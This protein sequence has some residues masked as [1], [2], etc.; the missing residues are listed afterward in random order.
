MRKTRI[1]LI[2][3]GTAGHLNPLVAVG[4]ELKLEA[5]KAG[6]PLEVSYMGT[7]GD[8]AESFSANDIKV[9]KIIGSKLRR[10][11]DVENLFEGPKLIIG[12]IQ[13]LW[14]LFWIMPDVVFSKGGSGAMAPV[15]AA[16]FYRI[17][18]FIHESDAVPSAT[19][20]VTG[21]FAKTIFISF[22]EVAARFAPAEQAK[23]ELVGSPLR[24]TL[25]TDLSTKEKAKKLLGLDPKKPVMLVLGGSQGS[26]RINNLIL[27]SLPD[28]LG[29]GIQVLHQ[30]GAKLF[31]DVAGALGGLFSSI[32]EMEK[33][34]YQAI[35]FFKGDMK[36]ALVAADLIISRSGS[37]IFE[38]AAFG[39][40]SILIPLPEAA[41]NHQ[42]MNARAY[43]DAGACIVMEEDDITVPLFVEQVTTIMSSNER[44]EKLSENARRFAKPDAASKIAVK[45]LESVNGQS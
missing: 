21:R 16:R 19:S 27:A 34:G 8:F 43:E 29:S 14:H 17:P 28:I 7:P 38:F 40:P 22:E 45:L 18:V 39:K 41:Q 26:H 12:L 31:E 25:F 32:E 1:T 44:L 35:D 37:S 13:S 23:C 42:L 36:D 10:Y 3:G 33:A 2:G 20:R 30:T 24:R 5:A 4:I 9:I 11:I 15:L 6:L